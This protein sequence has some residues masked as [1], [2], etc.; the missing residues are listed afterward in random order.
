MIVFWTSGSS[1]L[2]LQMVECV[3]WFVY[4]SLLWKTTVVIWQDW[5]KKS[6]Y[7]S[8]NLILN[9]KICKT[10]CETKQKEALY[11]KYDKFHLGN[12]SDSNWTNLFHL[13]SK[14][15]II[16]G[17]LSGLSSLILSKDAGKTRLLYQPGWLIKWYMAI[18]GTGSEL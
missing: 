4:R 14:H 15:L 6:S 18:T 10:K 2:G 11:W 3:V 5:M 12:C 7:N 9:P 16:P 8:P 17:L 13:T 1:S